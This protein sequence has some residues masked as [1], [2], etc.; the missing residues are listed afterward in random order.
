MV[1]FLEALGV[2]VGHIV[3]PPME[4]QTPS[5]T[6]VLSLAPPLKTLCSVQWMTVIIHF[7]ICQALAD[8][9]RRQLFQVPVSKQLLAS[10]IVSEFNNGIWVESPGETVT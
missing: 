2:L 4:M 5:A 3:V 9:L 6:W 1:Y 7:C 10:T 8:P